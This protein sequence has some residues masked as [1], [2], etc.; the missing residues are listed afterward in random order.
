[1]TKP[2]QR[3]DGIKLI[4]YTSITDPEQA[5]KVANEYLRVHATIEQFVTGSNRLDYNTP[6]AALE[7]YI[8]DI[9]WAKKHKEDLQPENE[10][11]R[12]EAPARYKRYYIIADEICAKNPMLRQH[13]HTLAQMIRRKLKPNKNDKMPALRT[14]ANALNRR[15]P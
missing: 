11:R 14:I 13:P 1:M 5:L 2:K 7:K 12:R 6:P 10:K 3:T 4:R 9:R 8:P 15:S